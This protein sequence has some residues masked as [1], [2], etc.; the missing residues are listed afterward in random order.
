[1]NVVESRAV[2]P[3][4]ELSDTLGTEIVDPASGER[5]PMARSVATFPNAR[6]IRKPTKS[7]RFT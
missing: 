5:I 6:T 7:F 1:M 2:N 3:V 4:S